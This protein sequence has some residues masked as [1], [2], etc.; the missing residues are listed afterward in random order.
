M[1]KR[2]PLLISTG[3]TLIAL[4][5]YS[6]TFVGAR[7]TPLFGFI[8]RLELATLDLRF[9]LRGAQAPDPRIVIV[10]IDQQTQEV[11][12]R[13]P[14]PRIHFAT[15]LDQ[16]RE[17]GAKVVA[18][19]I[20]FSQPGDTT[21]PIEALRE[22]VEKR[23]GVK[24]DPRLTRDLE[25]V[26]RE[27]DYDARFAQAIEKFGRVVLGNFFLF[28]ESDML[29]MTDEAL[30]RFANL[31][32][33]HPLPQ[34]VPA[35]SAQ[36]EQQSL[37]NVI[38]NMQDRKFVPRGAQANI[39]PL[40][41]ALPAETASAGFFNIFPDSDGAVR[42]VQLALPYGRSANLDEWDFYGSVV[43]HAIRLFL[44]VPSE[45][46]ALKYGS[47]GLDSLEF[48]ERIVQ[49]D[50][51]G[52]VV[53]NY[54]GGTRTY[55]YYS[56]GSVV[57]GSFPKGAFQDKLV[58]V[59][60]S[61]TGIG[62][63]R[64]TP[65]S[66][67]DFPG[68]EIHANT[69]DN[70]L[71]NDFIQRRGKQVAVDVFF[72]LLFGAP[73]G[74]GLGLVEPRRMWM[75]MGLLVPFFAVTYFAFTQLWWLNV[76]TPTA[77]LVANT[78]AIGLVRVLAVE[79][80]RRRTRDA[81]Q[82]Y[83][84]PEV[85]RRLLKSPDSVKPRKIEVSIMFTDVRGFTSLSEDLDAQE[86][87]HLL[88]HYLSEMTRIVFRNQ[89]T[90]DKYMGDGLM[91]FWGAPFEEPLHSPKAC[92]A[93]L[94]M[95]EKL[96]DL[97][98]EWQAEGKPRMD[99]GIGIHTGVASVG[100]MGSRLRTAYT[101]IGDAVN[102]ASRLEGM[103][104]T[105]G[106]RILV[107][108]ETR[109]KAPDPQLLFRELDWIRV[110]GKKQRVTIYE[111]PALRDGASEWPE[112]IALFEAGLTAYRTRDWVLAHA[113]FE[114]LLMRWP[115][116]GPGQLFLARCEDYLVSPPSALWDGVYVSKQK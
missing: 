96:R 72:I 80:E 71:N 105:Y 33:Y 11:L 47:E 79:R 86:V 83:L 68:V 116:D 32:A 2:A 73:L 70:I 1:T 66:T 62:D 12:G 74:M 41:L 7:P 20:T 38:R 57:R 81:F 111:L 27:F 113:C 55:A 13:W 76:V 35:A 91:A 51:L 64:A 104:K 17:D 23:G 24:R 9:D 101:V 94:G 78:L 45:K 65:Y 3:V 10:D 100:Q 40:T 15:L 75:A 37:H 108:E 61:A 21:Q 77:T 67:L 103:N 29:G 6:A 97:Q 63:L 39:E 99:I 82:Q 115:E 84:S 25:A 59:G 5:L 44:D 34:V 87:A 16:L 8:D 85:V 106:T 112:R 4:L 36:R 43:V 109:M 50:D 58:F 92:L 22:R 49:T 28:T 114:T 95:M 42:H 31:V 98:K 107:S 56:M 53:V 90:L 69:A 30:D 88:N 14:F 26:Q 18:F 89:G 19:D 46:V 110:T 93:A 52:Q 48:G 102:L 54:R 60:A